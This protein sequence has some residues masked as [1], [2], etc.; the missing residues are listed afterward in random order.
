M[1][2]LQRN[3][4]TVWYANYT[5]RTAVTSGGLYTGENVYEYTDPI[6]IRV[7]V[8]IPKGLVYVDN[9]GNHEQLDRSIVSDD[10]DVPITGTSVMWIDREPQKDPQTDEYLKN[11]YDYVVIQTPQRSFNYSAW[12]C[13]R[14]PISAK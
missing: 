4:R 3:L 10:P 7:H 8:G 2:L 1:R 13:S 6:P 11:D 14:V 5:G 9:F 12:G